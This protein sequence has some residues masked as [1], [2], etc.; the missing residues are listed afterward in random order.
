MSIAAHAPRA[1]QG[2]GRTPRLLRHCHPQPRQRSLRPSSARSH[3]PSGAE[4]G[5]P[6][7]PI[8]F[9]LAHSDSASDTEP[10]S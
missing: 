2:L 6:A 1:G 10:P 3:G 8:P 4:T 9:Q 5:A 7:V